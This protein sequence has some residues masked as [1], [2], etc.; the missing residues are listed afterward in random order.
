[1]REWR[2]YGGEEERGFQSPRQLLRIV[3]CPEMHEEDAG[4][5]IEHVAVQRGDL[6][7]MAERELS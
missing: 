2:P 7:R 5:L 3:I 1:L 4:L 6:V